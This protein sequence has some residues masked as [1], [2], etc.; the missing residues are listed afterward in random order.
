MDIGR[1]LRVIVVE[2]EQIDLAPAKRESPALVEDLH[3]QG[4]RM[5]TPPASAPARPASR[6]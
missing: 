6:E 5:V 4:D 2:P 3:P 1:Q